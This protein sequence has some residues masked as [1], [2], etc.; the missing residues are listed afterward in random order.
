MATVNRPPAGPVLG[1]GRGAADGAG[2]AGSPMFT[3]PRVLAVGGLA[4]VVLIVAYLLFSGSGGAEYHLLFTNG[5]QLVR[6][7]QVQVGGVP[8]GS[9]KNIEL[10]SNDQAEIT[11]E[12]QSSLLPLH[13]GTT[14][15]IR[16]PDLTS[17]AGR[18]VALSPGP[19]SNP[20][21]PSGSTLPTGA[22]EV[23]VDLD[24]LFNTLN[25]ATR[26]GLEEFI[27][28]NATQY[29]G[30]GKEI[31]AATPYFSTAL[32]A[33]DH[34]F[35]ELT[36]EEQVLIASLVEG[37]KTLETL[38][39]HGSQL[40]SL[41]RNGANTFGAVASEA[42]NLEEGLKVLP[43]ALHEGNAALTGVPS[44]VQSLEGLVDAS[45]PNFK[46]LAPFLA[47]LRGLFK[48]GTP[49]TAQL[50]GA[51]SKPGPNNDLTD[52][53][54][55][56]PGLYKSLQT[57]SPDTV[58][59]LDQSVPITNFFGPYSPD[60]IGLFR[61]FGL[62]SGYRD[63]N[64]QYERVSP[65]FANFKLEGGKLKPTTP[66]QGIEGLSIKQLRRCPGGATQ[67]AEDGSSPFTDEGLLGCDPSEVP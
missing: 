53:V 58:K 21:L 56:V 37:A 59:A 61:T 67:P 64:G 47:A 49:V 12:V 42:K 4:V 29:Q 36:R 46:Q 14:A 1:N 9:V 13:R 54:R 15:L 45:K 52:F 28:G 38:A 57:A 27:K 31:N 55:A 48:Q 30:V 19:N 40:G 18:Y 44:T 7:D 20:A 23:P 60:L 43:K 22:T 63:A 65:D 2:G 26:R 3:L 50:A 16:V 66:T 5:G 41:V 8:V 32:K 11:I 51:F 10:T 17:V 62:L 39:N 33:T 6:G 34:V 24:E 25:P 35:N